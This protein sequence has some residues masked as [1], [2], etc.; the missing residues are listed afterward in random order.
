MATVK[1]TYPQDLPY[2]NKALVAD[3]QRAADETGISITVGATKTGHRERTKGGVKSRHSKYQAADIHTFTVDGK[4][5]TGS[6][7]PSNSKFKYYGDIFV[8]K[9]Q[10]WGYV[11]NKE[12]GND[13]AVLWW[14]DSKSAGNHYNHIHV[15]N[16]TG[17]ASNTVSKPETIILGAPSSNELQNQSISSLASPDNR[18]YHT[19]EE[20]AQSN[21]VV[22]KYTDIRTQ[23]ANGI[24][25]IVDVVVDPNVADRQLNDLS[26]SNFQGSLFNF[27]NQ[28]CQKPF[29]EFW[30]DTYGDKYTFIVRTPPFTRELYR[31]LPTIT[32]SEKDVISDSLNFCNEAYS[33]YQ[34]TPSANYIG[35][36]E[37]L[38]LYMKAVFFSEYAEIWG[39]KPM[40]ITS[41]YISYLK[42]DASVQIE[43]ALDDFKYVI[44][45]HS[46]LPFTR[47]GSITINGDRR[48]KRGMRIFYEPTGE[49]YYVDSV[50]NK[51][52]VID[53][54]IERVTTLNVSRG[55]VAKYVDNDIEDT[56]T[57]NYFNLINYD[58][59]PKV[60][61][62]RND[63]EPN[64]AKDVNAT[65]NHQV[66]LFSLWS[67]SFSPDEVY[68]KPKTGV[69]GDEYADTGF[70]NYSGTEGDIMQQLGIGAGINS[71]TGELYTTQADAQYNSLS[72]E[73]YQ[74]NMANCEQIV[75]VAEKYKNLKFELVGHCSEYD[76]G[77]SADELWR[78]GYKRAKSVLEILCKMYYDLIINDSE[79]SE[80]DVNRMVGEFRSRFKCTSEAAQ[81]PRVDNSTLLGQKQNRRVE[82]YVEGFANEDNDRNQQPEQNMPL[83]GN[84][85]VN[86]AVFLF[87]LRRQQ[88]LENRP[89]TMHVEIYRD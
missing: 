56:F 29:V 4:N 30:G 17:R 43:K 71:E 20:Y 77:W 59:D 11:R 14:F 48:I 70:I 28:L 58:K 53:G 1:Y 37:H 86:R 82:I 15:S 23:I 78:L 75:Q 50:S 87:F 61:E 38:N 74:K 19:D 16:R 5:Y 13:K 39:S 22:S 3:L 88:F 64:N 24:W 85:K 65:L 60:R 36:D 69:Y 47:L 83:Y 31:S 33:W 67:E 9:L 26:I 2:L 63:T 25:Q 41:Q 10:S 32:V 57:P 7:K 21:T 18:E 42:E 84:W 46:Y 34:F 52:S 66:A 72:F 54:I 12:N 51:F 44:N 40:S 73:E 6:R 49:Y 79:I 55:M 76:K 45:C 62:Q 8:A 68:N 80:V 35:V 27:F 81:N 89:N